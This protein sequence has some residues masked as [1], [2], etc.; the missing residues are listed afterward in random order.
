[1]EYT[2]QD[3]REDIHVNYYQGE[4][5]TEDGSS[6]FLETTRRFFI[7]ED[8]SNFLKREYVGWVKTN[9]GKDDGKP[10]EGLLNG[11]DSQNWTI[12]GNVFENPELLNE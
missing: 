9:S 12:V 11:G 1:M 4:Y 6:P 3:L 8:K 2:N 5:W 7:K 10:V